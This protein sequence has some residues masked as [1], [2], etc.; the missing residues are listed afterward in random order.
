MLGF[1]LMTDKFRPALHDFA[2]LL[3]ARHS[4][5]FFLPPLPSTIHASAHTPDTIH[6]C[7]GLCGG[8][9]GALLPPRCPA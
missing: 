2:D 3:P 1:A 7:T 6:E 8:G 4:H 9:H 5:C